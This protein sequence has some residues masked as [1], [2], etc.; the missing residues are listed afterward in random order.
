MVK[1]KQRPLGNT[2]LAQRCP[3]SGNSY[4]W[5]TAAHPFQAPESQSSED[6]GEYEEEEQGRE[7]P[8][9]SVVQIRL[10]MCRVAVIMPGTSW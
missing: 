3:L 10:K 1:Q 4:F 6:E 2:L 9:E 7:S 8:C 5:R